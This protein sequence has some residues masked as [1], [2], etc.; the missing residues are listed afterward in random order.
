M[1]MRNRHDG[2][3]TPGWWDDLPPAVRRRFSNRVPLPDSSE[4]LLFAGREPVPT[5][6]SVFRDL[7]RLAVLFLVV[8]V[9]NLLF[10]LIALSFLA[11]RAPFG[12]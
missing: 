12:D 9:A 3:D 1:V 11:G 6:P 5:R 4:P 10:L 7:S 2:T 8:A